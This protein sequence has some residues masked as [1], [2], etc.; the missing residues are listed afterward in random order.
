MLQAVRDDW[1]FQ[2]YYD[3]LPVWGFIGKVGGG[4]PGSSSSSSSSSSRGDSS[5]QGARR[6]QQQQEQQEQPTGTEGA[7]AV[8]LTKGGRTR[9]AAGGRGH[10]STAQHGTTE[11]GS[12]RPRG[13]RQDK[14]S[15]GNSSR[16]I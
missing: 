2:M 16:Q 6:R 1:Y 8:V 11:L 13:C 12:C 7:S 10:L 3:N 15:R 4:G 9:Q 14:G 5:S